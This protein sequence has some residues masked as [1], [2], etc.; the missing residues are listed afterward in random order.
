MTVVEQRPV[1]AFPVDIPP[2]GRPAEVDLGELTDGLPAIGL[3]ELTEIAGLQTRVDRKYL[4]PASDLPALRAALP[5]GTRRLVVDGRD[6]VG[7]R[8]VYF[9]TPDRTA[10]R[11]AAGRRRRRFKVRTRRY[12]TGGCWVEVKTRGPRGTLSLIHI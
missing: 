8:S 1:T 7:Y 12:D 10:F 5:A 2:V 11:L 9:D 4:V 3:A 6:R